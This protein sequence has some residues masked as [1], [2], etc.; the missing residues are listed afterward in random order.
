[1][2]KN[3]VRELTLEEMIE[4]GYDARDIQAKLERKL[5]KRDSD[6]KQEQQIKAREVVVSAIKI[7]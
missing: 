2:D 7:I 6:R 4:L 3:A 1:M 5:A